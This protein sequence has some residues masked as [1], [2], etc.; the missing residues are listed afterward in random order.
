MQCLWI[1]PSWFFAVVVASWFFGLAHTTCDT[2][3]EFLA[4]P[5]L[6]CDCNYK[7]VFGRREKESGTKL[8]AGSKILVKVASSAWDVRNKPFCASFPKALRDLH[9]ATDCC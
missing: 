7:A 2:A 9:M 6:T 1:S 5:G 4:D 3:I 8:N